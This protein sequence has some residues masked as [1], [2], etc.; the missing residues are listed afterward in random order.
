[1]R[2]VVRRHLEAFFLAVAI[3]GALASSITWTS[4]SDGDVFGPADTIHAAWKS[5]KEI[6]EPSFRLC[7]TSGS[8]S[9]SVDGCGS[10]VW[11]AVRKH[12]QTY[13]IT[14]TVPGVVSEGGFHLQMEDKS[15]AIAMSPAFSLSAS[16]ISGNAKSAHT[17]DSSGDDSDDPPA[18]TISALAHPPVSSATS[19]GGAAS[20]GA[21]TSPG[22]PTSPGLPTSPGTPASPG[23]ASSPG[24]SAPPGAS[25]APGTPVSSST[26]DLSVTRHPTPKAAFAVP[27]AFVAVV[28]VVAGALSIYHRRK[29]NKERLL[30]KQNREV[31]RQS[32]LRS[33]ATTSSVKSRDLEKAMDLLSMIRNG[34]SRDDSASSAGFRREARQPTRLSY[35]AEAY[36]PRSD[37]TNSRPAAPV[38]THRSTARSSRRV[39]APRSP[40]LGTAGRD[41]D[42]EHNNADVNDSVISDYMYPSPFASPRLS[43]P[44]KPARYEPPSVR[45]EKL[46]PLTPQPGL[47]NTITRAVDSSRRR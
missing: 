3:E 22:I 31:S 26:P 36:R 41:L 43:A 21:V 12:D 27:I 20:P 1:M 15:G 42:N 30:D 33:V 11:P 29:L 28:L 16:E 2:T 35:P 24:A 34:G 9:D 10:T 25:K 7:A 45:V 17:S 38:S 23:N 44:R 13:S 32:S 5:A 14:L 4:P 46:L 18:M 47:H 40:H 39:P 37:R 19:K 8:S 6:A